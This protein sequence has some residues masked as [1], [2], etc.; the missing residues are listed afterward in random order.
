MKKILKLAIII[1]ALGLCIP[2][3][4]QPQSKTKSEYWTFYNKE[5]RHLCQVNGLP[6]WDDMLKECFPQKVGEKE[7]DRMKL[8]SYPDSVP[9]NYFDEENEAFETEDYAIPEIF[10]G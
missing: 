4:K 7:L 10:T 6:Y 8:Q 9:I 1:L 5:Y 3:C 2:S